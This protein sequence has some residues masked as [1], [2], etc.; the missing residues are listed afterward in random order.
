MLIYDCT[1]EIKQQ[2]QQLEKRKKSHQGD[3]TFRWDAHV[4]DPQELMKFGIIKRGQD[5]LSSESIRLGV[6]RS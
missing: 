4:R 6:R 2:R 3:G 5:A 1:E